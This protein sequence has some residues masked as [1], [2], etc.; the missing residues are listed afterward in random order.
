MSKTFDQIKAEIS[1]EMEG[2]T[3]ESVGTVANKKV[4]TPVDAN[5]MPDVAAVTSGV[6]GTIVSRP[7]SEKIVL[8]ANTFQFMECVAATP[9][10]EK[11]RYCV[12]EKG[13]GAKYG[14]QFINSRGERAHIVT[15]DLF[16]LLS[17]VLHSASKKMNDL[18]KD[19]EHAKEQRD[20]YKMT[21]E[22]L[23]KNGVID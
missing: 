10:R 21:I 11:K 8:D 7:G 17:G 15:R 19:L 2:R 18:S 20:L 9:G 3:D 16:I 14:N 22:A 23:K 6:I 4:N 5:G 13:K 1:K 12:V